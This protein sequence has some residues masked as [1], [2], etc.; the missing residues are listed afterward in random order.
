MMSAAVW[1]VVR[2][3]GRPVGPWRRV[4]DIAPLDRCITA[5][6]AARQIAPPDELQR[7]GA[8]SIPR[9]GLATGSG[10]RQ[11]LERGRGGQITHRLGGQNPQ[12]PQ[13]SR[14]VPG[15]PRGGP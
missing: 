6:P 1:L 11:R 3:M 5:W 10:Y 12:N 9:I 7:L 13:K 15:A 14:V 8:R 2:R 4:V